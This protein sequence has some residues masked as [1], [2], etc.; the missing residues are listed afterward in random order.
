ME[1]YLAKLDEFI[2]KR[3]QANHSD[4]HIMA[5]LVSVGWDRP[6]VQ[7]RL[8]GETSPFAPAQEQPVQ[9]QPVQ[10]VVEE[11]IKI[12]KSVFSVGLNGILMS[13]AG[14]LLLFSVWTILFAVREKIF[15]ATDEII[16]TEDLNSLF[17]FLTGVLAILTPLFIFLRNRL[18]KNIKN[19]PAKLQDSFFKKT[20]R[21]NFYASFVIGCLWGFLALFNILAQGVF[22]NSNIT[23][24]MIIDSSTA[25]LL[26]A[27]FA[28][29]FWT[30]KKREAV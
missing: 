25:T 26:A 5:Q 10:P 29:F 12:N 1:E 21:V 7:A 9:F 13:V 22:A 8:A 3:R 28:Y 23:P 4:E 19:D 20:I 2:E 27:A 16:P 17:I 30:Y 18:E 6:M 11:K 15:P 14:W 24:Q